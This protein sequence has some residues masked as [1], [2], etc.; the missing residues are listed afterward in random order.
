MPDPDGRAELPVACTL[1]PA[2]GAERM[3]RWQRLAAAADPVSRREEGRLVVRYQP[4]PGVLEELRDLAGAEADCCSFADWAVTEQGA[5]RPWLS[6]PA[7]G[8]RGRSSR[9]PRCSA[10]PSG[11]LRPPGAG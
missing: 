9:S 8:R 4:M 11:A 2:D 6:R 5:T 7:R 1:G 10:W 3:R